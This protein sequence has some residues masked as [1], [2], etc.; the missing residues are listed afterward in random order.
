MTKNSWVFVTGVA[1]VFA[2]AAVAFSVGSAYKLNGVKV[3]PSTIQPLPKV[4]LMRSAWSEPQYAA[5]VS[6]IGANDHL[7]LKVTPA[8]IELTAK[9]IKFYGEFMSKLDAILASNKELSVSSICMGSSCSNSI[10]SVNVV[11]QKMEFSV[12]N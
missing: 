1:W 5:L 4:A 2:I 11:G 10:M 7:S 3:S 9:E 8:G 12:I 6:K